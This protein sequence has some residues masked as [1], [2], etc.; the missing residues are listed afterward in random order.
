M[1]IPHIIAFTD[2]EVNVYL[3]VIPR[4]L[5]FTVLRLVTSRR[6]IPHTIFEVNVYL[7]VILT[8]LENTHSIGNSRLEVT[9]QF[10]TLEKASPIV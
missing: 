10:R 5:I 3:N 9:Q 7:N 6:H 8:R 1:E 4:T 2:L